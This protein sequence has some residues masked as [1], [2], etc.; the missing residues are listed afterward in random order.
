[1]KLC[2]LFALQE[3]EELKP[4]R[5]SVE[6]WLKQRKVVRL[7]KRIVGPFWRN[8]EDQCP[9]ILKRLAIIP[10]AD[11]SKKKDKKNNENDS[12]TE[13]CFGNNKI[14]ESRKSSF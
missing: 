3:D 10:L 12:M 7:R 1:M 5:P 6:S 8:Q 9:N 13:K 4:I 14:P 2:S 11:F